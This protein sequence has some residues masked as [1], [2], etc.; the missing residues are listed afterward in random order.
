MQ[1]DQFIASLDLEGLAEN[2]WQ[3]FSGKDRDDVAVDDAVMTV[4][5]NHGRQVM[6]QFFRSMSPSAAFEEGG[7]VWK[8][9][10]TSVLDVLSRFGHVSVERP[11]FRS[12]RNGPTRCL[13]TERAGLVH[14]L[15]TQG[16]ARIAAELTAQLPMGQVE[17]LFQRLGV[18]GASRSSILRLVSLVSQAWEGE[19]E[20]HERALREGFEIPA[21][22]KTVMVSLD[23]VMLKT[24]SSNTAEQKAQAKADGRI[25]KGPAGFSEASVGIVAFFDQAGKRLATRRY[26][27]M[28]EPDKRTTKAW[29]RAELQHVRTQRPDVVVVAIADGSPNNWTFLQSLDPDHELVDFYHTAEHLHRH[30]SQASGAGTRDTQEKLKSMRRRLLTVPN[31]AEKIFAEMQALREEAGTEAPSTKKTSGRRQPT[32]WDRH[33]DRMDFASA[34]Q[35]NLPIGSGVT[36]STC[37]WLVCD[38]LRGTGMRWSPTGGQAVMTLR[39]WVTSNEFNTG[40]SIAMEAITQLA[41]A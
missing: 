41:A 34:I 26:A 7:T 23:G 10:V 11:L 20:A 3:V 19:R 37:K 31:A 28:P 15:W 13:V 4:L 32:F 30:V 18:V 17:Q 8:P 36:E 29:L 38:R 39:G 12:V 21:E 14:G 6:P 9:V 5:M 1:R 22:T 2:L 16:A 27:R 35:A 25:D 40:W 24:R 33:K